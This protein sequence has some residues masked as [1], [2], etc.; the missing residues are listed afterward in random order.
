MNFRSSTRLK[1]DGG[2]EIA[3]SNSSSGSTALGLLRALPAL[4]VVHYSWPFCSEP[5]WCTEEFMSSALPWSNPA[6][7]R[8]YARVT[9]SV[10]TF[11]AADLPEAT[12]DIMWEK[13]VAG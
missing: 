11:A 13:L 1:T 2:P 3:R 7:M 12:S 8:E 9:H 4:P 6:V 5:Y 10:S